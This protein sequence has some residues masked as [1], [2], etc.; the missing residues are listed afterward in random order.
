MPLRE[1]ASETLQI[2]KQGSFRSPGGD[3]ISIIEEQNYAEENTILY[4][5][6]SAK[7]LLA[8]KVI[9]K[10]FSTTVTVTRETSQQAASRLVQKEGIANP[11]VLNFASAKNPGGG[12]QNGAKAQEEDLA[13]SSGLYPCLL[14][15]PGYYQNNRKSGTFF[16]TDHII[17]SPKVPWFRSDKGELLQNP[18]LAS[19]ITAPAP[20]AGQI[21]LK[22]QGMGTEIQE[23][24]W[25]R[26]ALVLAIAREQGHKTLILGAWGCGVF[27]NEPTMVAEGFAHHLQD[28]QF[29]GCFENV[30]FAI[31]DTSKNRETLRAFEEV[32]G[33]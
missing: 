14:K 30:C 15:Q 1:I 19:V 21:R 11:V 18:Y 20:N 12:F 8:K 31:Y 9:E 27:R 23:V 7:A 13:R 10:S 29:Q 5:P 3:T 16:Y 25:Q 28:S 17:Y 6:E 26:A 4:T 33:K 22:K 2:L 32:F 24:L